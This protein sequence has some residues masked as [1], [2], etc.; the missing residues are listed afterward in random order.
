MPHPATPS[1]PFR[2][3]D[4]LASDGPDYQK[5]ADAQIYERN[6]QTADNVRGGPAGAVGF[7]TGK[8]KGSDVGAG[9]DAG[10]AALGGTLDPR[11][12]DLQA[13][14]QQL[15]DLNAKIESILAN[16]PPLLPP[17]RGN[18]NPIGDL[19]TISMGGASTGRTEPNSQAEAMIM[20]VVKQNPTIGTEVVM[21]E[22]MKDPRWP[23]ADGWVKMQ[24]VARSP[25]GRSITIHWVYNKK[26]GQADDFKFK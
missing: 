9:I 4:S 8:D 21:K 17:A 12:G 7:L 25:D 13:A 2:N 5:T 23:G 10:L 22:P 11:I 18:P 19:G 14:L 1:A 6:M 15:K 26:T 16:N 20:D 3:G 24:E